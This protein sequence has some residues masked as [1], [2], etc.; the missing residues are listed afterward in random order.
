M[1]AI[2]HVGLGRYGDPLDYD[3]D[4]N[5]AKELARVTALGGYLMIVVPVGRESRI[6]FNA[7]RIYRYD[8]FLMM[9]PDMVVQEFSLIPDDKSQDGLIRN[10]DK[11]LADQQDYGC[12]CFLLRKCLKLEPH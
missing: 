8:D 3:G 1:H 4:L 11:D 5:A 2:E 9:F 10:A 12:G 7:H 6:Q